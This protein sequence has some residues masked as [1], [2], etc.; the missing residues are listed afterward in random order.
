MKISD[1]KVI[2]KSKGKKN[3]KSHRKNLQM[4][5]AIEFYLSPNL[6][7]KNSAEICNDFLKPPY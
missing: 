3:L 5:K 2:S 1:K 6:N 7:F 4:E